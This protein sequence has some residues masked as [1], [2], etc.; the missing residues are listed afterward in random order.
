MTEE[1]E[2]TRHEALESQTGRNYKVAA[3]LLAICGT[4]YGAIYHE[5]GSLVFSIS[6]M[7]MLI[8]AL[9]PPNELA[10]TFLPRLAFRLN[11]SLR[12][13]FQESDRLVRAFMIAISIGGAAL[14]CKYGI[15]QFS[16]FPPYLDVLVKRIGPFLA[17]SSCVLYPMSVISNRIHT[18]S[19]NNLDQPIRR[20]EFLLYIAVLLFC[21]TT[22][23]GSIVFQTEGNVRSHANPESQYFPSQRQRNF[24]ALG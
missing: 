19:N 21:V 8:F 11:K 12:E 5:K 22:F 7:V 24:R 3:I 18:L 1:S 16:L 10:P 20:Y 9:V 6:S 13:T 17:V 4:I 2:L 14:V 23:V 15:T